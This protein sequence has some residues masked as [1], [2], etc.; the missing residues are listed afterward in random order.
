MFVSESRWVILLAQLETTDSGRTW[1]SYSS[2]Y[3]LPAPNSYEVV[4]AESLVGY[5]TARGGIQRTL[6]GGSHWVRIAMPGTSPPDPALSTYR[7]PNV[8]VGRIGAGLTYDVKHGYLLMF[9][10]STYVSDSVS[11]PPGFIETNGLRPY[12]SNETWTWDGNHWTLLHPP[13]SPPASSNLAMAY[14]PRSQRVI[15]EGRWAWDGTTWT[16]LHPAHAPPYLCCGFLDRDLGSLVMIGVETEP[17]VAQHIVMWQWTGSDWIKTVPAGSP[18]WR[19]DFGFAYDPDRRQAMLVGGYFVKPGSRDTTDVGETWLLRQGKWSQ[20]SPGSVGPSGY[21]KAAY[22]EAR[23]QL[24]VVVGYAG[25]PPQWVTETWT[26]DGAAWTLRNPQHR[27]PGALSGH[28]LAY[29]AASKRVVLFGGKS[30]MLHSNPLDQTWVWDGND[31][32]QLT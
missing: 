20:W 12:L 5:G 26:W 24:V 13:S 30:D 3:L 15:L 18:P 28:S 27:P 4:F 8:P 32:V 7:W 17:G 16:E 6:D 31:W 19:G 14:D 22:D 11:S 9:G 10:G 1:H 29:D 23:H 2:D 21:A 25:A